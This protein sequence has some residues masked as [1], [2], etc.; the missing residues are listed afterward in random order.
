MT[1]E[2]VNFALKCPVPRAAPL[3][4]IMR[5]PRQEELCAGHGSGMGTVITAIGWS[6]TAR[7]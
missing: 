6:L 3:W 4:D 5:A 1:E 7:S 2:L